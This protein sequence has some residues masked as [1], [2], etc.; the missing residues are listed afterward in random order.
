MMSRA[1]RI[2]LTTAAVVFATVLLPWWSVA[3]VGFAFGWLTPSSRPM[4]AGLAGLLGWAA[5]LLLAVAQGPVGVLLRRLGVLF[6][7]PA[8]GL[9][10]LSLLLVVALVWSAASLARVAKTSLTIASATK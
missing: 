8:A 1:G 2:G 10:I 6:H 4:D 9:P 3:L 5:L 7:L